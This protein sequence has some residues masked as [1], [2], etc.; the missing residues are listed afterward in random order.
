MK[1]Q[2]DKR[3]KIVLLFNGEYIEDG[4]TPFIEGC[5]I[6]RLDLEEHKPTPVKMYICNMA[7]ICSGGACPCKQE[8]SADG[9][10]ITI[11]NGRCS[12]NYDA[13]CIEVG[14]R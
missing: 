7:S 11:V 9:E 1:C 2:H 12:R 13:C 5:E 10:C 3:V 8:H 4:Y 14:E 6:C